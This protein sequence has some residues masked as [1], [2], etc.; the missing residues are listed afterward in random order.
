MKN[1]KFA[2]RLFFIYLFIKCQKLWFYLLNFK[3]V[4]RFKYFE[5][6]MEVNLRKQK[7]EQAIL[8]QEIQVLIPKKVKKGLS[9]YIPLTRLARARI[10][11]M[12]LAN[13]GERM[14]KHNLS[15]NEHLQIA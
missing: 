1:L 10:R 12:V 4:N 3:R 8:I 11:A 9:K 5:K 6:K 2:V 7:V 15:I 14:K 13:F